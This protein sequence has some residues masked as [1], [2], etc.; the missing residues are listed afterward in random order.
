MLTVAHYSKGALS[1]AD[2]YIM[3]VYLRDFY[4]REFK[5]LKEAENE[6][7]EKHKR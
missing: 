5:N 4:I 3:P 1:V 2:M 7:I 6:A